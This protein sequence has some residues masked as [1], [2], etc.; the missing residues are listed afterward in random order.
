[1]NKVIIVEGKTDKERLLEIIEEPV[2]I[3]CTYGTLGYQRLEEMLPQLQG[4]DIYLLTDADAAGEKLRKQIKREFPDVHHLYTDKM[5]REVAATPV[6]YL[7]EL[8]SKAHFLVKKR[9]E[10]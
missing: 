3:I 9:L 2:E 7:T 8:L 1:M 10:F 5:Y 4:K 6:A